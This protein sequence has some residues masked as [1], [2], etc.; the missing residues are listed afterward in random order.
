MCEYKS[1]VIV[2]GD[3]YSKMERKIYCKRREIKLWE[4]PEGCGYYKEFKYNKKQLAT[5]I[6]REIFLK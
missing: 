1:N 4:C 2:F 3:K 6:N 5:K